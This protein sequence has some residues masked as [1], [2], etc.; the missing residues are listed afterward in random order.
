MRALRRVDPLYVLAAAL[1]AAALA[2]TA[3]SSS[4]DRTGL[5]RSASVYD[6]GPGGTALLRQWLESVGLRTVVLQGDRFDPDP[7]REPVLFLLGASEPL[8]PGDVAALRRYVSSGGTLVVATEAAL[9][10]APLLDAYRVRLTG[11]V[12]GSVL[13]AVAPLGTGAGA[14][15]VSVDRGRQVDAGERALPVARAAHG[16][17]AVAVPDGRGA[18]YVVGSLAPFLTGQITDA[19]NGRFALGL[20]AAAAR[21]GGAVAFDEYHHGAHPPPDVLAILERTWPGRA[22]LVAGFLVFGYL[23]V[24]GRRL[25]PPLPLEH[26]P[27]RSALDHVRAF[28]G[29][30]RR[31]GRTEIARDRL[32]RDLRFGVARAVGLDADAPMERLLAAFAQISPERAAEARA[33]DAQLAAHSPN[34]ELLRIVRRID[35]LLRPEEPPP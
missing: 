26:R 17:L 7:S 12:A 3:A 35:A 19:D 10:E 29:L 31:S 25:G 4:G 8:T 21:S 30:V 11:F 9:T 24:T 2:V 5:S 13:E 34:A 27:A 20:A 1:F 32:R 23:A 15:R 16:D 33:I 22:L 14:R 6:Q 18:L 28:A